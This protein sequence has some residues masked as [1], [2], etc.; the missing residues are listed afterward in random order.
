M[1]VH[2]QDVQPRAVVV[3]LDSTFQRVVPVRAVVRLPPETGHVLGAIAVVPGTVRLLG[4]RDAI[5]AIDS[6][7]TEPL[8]VARAD[9][10]VEETLALDTSG[11][12]GARCCRPR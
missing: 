1:D 8:E 7:R 11:S 3:A 4:P 2:V 6:V 9:G 12:G 5:E 10:P